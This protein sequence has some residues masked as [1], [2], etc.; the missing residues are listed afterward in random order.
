M[1][2]IEISLKNGKAILLETRGKVV[3]KNII[4]RNE[5]YDAFWD[6]FQEDGN[7]TDY[8][9]AFAYTKWNDGT[10][11]PKYPLK[12]V[13][14]ATCAFLATEF[15]W[16]DKVLRVD[17]SEATYLYWT[18][19]NNKFTH[20]GKCDLSSATNITG[21]FS[22]CFNLKSIEEIVSH[23]DLPWHDAFTYDAGLEDITFSGVIGKNI[24]LANSDKLTTASVQSIIDHLKDLTGTTSQTLTFHATVKNNLTQAQKDAI[25]AKNWQLA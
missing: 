23:E 15:A 18:F 3:D 12:F 17:L 16:A 8:R 21:I 20:L 10:F 1:S 5:S 13:G 2:N 25:A 9:Y 11:N 22:L 19:R 6:M 24:S 14:D 7:R 4:V